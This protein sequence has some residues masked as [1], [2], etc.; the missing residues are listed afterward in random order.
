[1][2]LSE[3]PSKKGKTLDEKFTVPMTREMKER[4]FRLKTEGKDHQAWV[5]GVLEKA[6]SEIDGISRIKK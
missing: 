5:R 1:M 2:K 6:L 4:I 3:I